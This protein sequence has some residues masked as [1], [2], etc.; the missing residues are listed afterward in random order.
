MGRVAEYDTIVVG[1][2]FFGCALAEHAKKQQGRHTVVLER[3][4]DSLQRASYVNQAR[5]HNGY[6]YPRSLL[7][8]LRC[9]V[10]F[11]RFIADFSECVVDDFDKYYAI[12]KVFGKVTAEQY[13]R[14]CDRIGAPIA[15]APDEVQRLFNPDLIEAVFSV[16]ECAFDPVKLKDILHRRLH[17]AG[18]ET[19]F[20]TE[21]LRIRQT[22]EGLLEV[23]CSTPEG[24]RTMCARS[25]LNCTYARLNK[26]LAASDLP[27]L[28]LK[29]E[30]T[31]MAL[32]EVPEEVAHRGITVMCGPFFSI[33]PFPP[34]GLHSLSHVRYTPHCEWKDTRESEYMDAYEYFDRVPRKS[35][36]LHMIKDA[37]R[38]MPCLEKC[39]QVDSLWEV[40]TVLPKSELDDSRPVLFAADWGLPNLT[41]LMG[42]KIDNIYDIIEF[43]ID[44]SEAKGAA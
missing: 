18:V 43:G 30:L 31:E 23:V 27:K 6:H 19:L 36:G 5:I 13:R 42:G 34:R 9:R 21:A 32:V 4:S 33:M 22:D 24:E 40:K 3:E 44:V 20:R 39:R 26:L 12:G 16:R 28:Y 7:T 29:H 35:H 10:D 14:F 37:A 25:V 1:G 38:Y 17:D 41:C 2:G 11:P 15:E 8:A